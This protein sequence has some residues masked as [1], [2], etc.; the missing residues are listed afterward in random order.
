MCLLVHR[1][2]GSLP[3]DCWCTGGGAPSQP[4]AGAQVAGLPSRPTGWCLAPC[5][6][7]G[8]PSCRQLLLPS[9]AHP[10]AHLPPH[11]QGLP[12]RPQVWAPALHPGPPALQLPAVRPQPALC[13][14]RLPGSMLLFAVGCS[15]EHQGWV[16]V[17]PRC[18]ALL[19]L[20]LACGCWCCL[21]L[22]WWPLNESLF[23]LCFIPTHAPLHSATLDSSLLK[24]NLGHHRRCRA[25]QPP[26]NPTTATM[27]SNQLPVV[28]VCGLGI[29]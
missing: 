6:G 5:W 21:A 28:V 15:V 3:A 29:I 19:L 8:V 13:P 22:R 27:C 14:L 12:H 17:S 4:T 11:L 2:Q 16:A 24:A 10:P 9:P 1:S 26:P 23:G 7:G 18:L 25:C 20:L